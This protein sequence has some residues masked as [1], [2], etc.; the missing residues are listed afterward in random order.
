M[1][2]K[3]HCCMG[4]RLIK[5]YLKD[6][7]IYIKELEQMIGLRNFLA[8]AYDTVDEEQMWLF[9]LKRTPELKEDIL[10]LMS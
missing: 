6:I 9:I 2:T 8:H 7:L 1:A 4:E 3:K 5:E 10:K